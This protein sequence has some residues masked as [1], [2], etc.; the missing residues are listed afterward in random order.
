[1]CKKHLKILTQKYME[2]H[3]SFNKLWGYYDM[4]NDREF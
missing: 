2:Y 1:M 4:K 3:I